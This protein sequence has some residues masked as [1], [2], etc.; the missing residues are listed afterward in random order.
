MF[1]FIREC[2]LYIDYNDQIVKL[3]NNDTFSFESTFSEL[4]YSKKTLHNRSSLQNVLVRE[5][6][7][8]SFSITSY[9][10]KTFKESLLLELFGWTNNLSNLVWPNSYESVPKFFKIIVHDTRNNKF[11]VFHSCCILDI[12]IPLSKDIFGK[13]SMGV[14]CGR[15]ELTNYYAIPYNANVGLEYFPLSELVISTD[16]QI[17]NSISAT[18]SMTNEISWLN[19][20]TMHNRGLIVSKEKALCT[21]KT[22]SIV[23][24]MYLNH[25][26]PREIEP[27]IGNFLL[28][29]S[30]FNLS[31]DNSLIMPRVSSEEVFLQSLDVKPTANTNTISIF[32][33]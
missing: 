13:F 8:I 14:E 11:Y 23:C 4:N 15:L 31:L 3:L 32:L 22:L 33:D 5:S 18:I 25:N 12:S 20:K 27:I 19:P 24:S 28:S 6:N 2:D 29:Q 26:K 30:G 1:T 16:S 9:F 10:T 21:D 17:Y 7:I